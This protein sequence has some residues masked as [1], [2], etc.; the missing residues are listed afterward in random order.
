M[1]PAYQGIAKEEGVRER[2]SQSS[3]RKRPGVSERTLGENKKFN[4]KKL[5]TKL[6]SQFSPKEKM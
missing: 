5:K 3:V 2:Q 6:M 1:K 4:L